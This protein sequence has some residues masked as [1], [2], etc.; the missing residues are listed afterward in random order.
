V[1]S[2][3]LGILIGVMVLPLASRAADPGPSPVPTAGPTGDPL[4]EVVVIGHYELFSDAASGYTN[5]PLPV[6]KIP[7][8]L[9]IVDADL[10]KAADL[11]TLADVADYTPGA[12]DVG[13]PGGFGAFISLRGFP[14]ANALDGINFSAISGANY[15]L[16]FAVMDRLE[17]IQGPSA[18]VYGV[19]SAGGLVNFVT[20][21]AATATPS[22]AILQGGSW[23]SW[24]FE[25][26][27]AGPLEAGGGAHGIAIA[28][29]DQGD[30][31]TDQ[32]QHQKVVLY[33]GANGNFADSVTAYVHGGYQKYQGTSFDGLPTE[34]DG[35]PAPLP[36]DFFIGSPQMT[37]N[38]LI[39]HAESNLTWHAGDALDVS[40][41][42]NAINSAGHGSTVP[43]SCCLDA[44]GNLVLDISD[45]REIKGWDYGAGI[46]ATYRLDQVGLQ[47]SFL[48][49][50]ALY[51]DDRFLVVAGSPSFAGEPTTTVNIFSGEAALTTAFDSARLIGEPDRSFQELKTLTLST[52]SVIEVLEHGSVLL[53]AAYSSPSLTNAFDDSRQDFHLPGNTLLRT[54]LMYEFAPHANAYASYS[55][56]F[57][58]QFLVDQQDR[59]LAPLVGSQYEIGVK[60]KPS[61][62]QLLLTAA[63]FAITQKNA[64]QFV[65]TVDGIDRYQ[66]IGELRHRGIELAA[67]GHVTAQWQINAGYTYLNARI[68]GDT[69]STIVGRTELFQPSRTASLFS[70]YTFANEFLRGFSA[71]AGVRYVGSERTAYDESTRDIPGYGLLDSSLAY[72]GSHWT[73]Q[74]NAHNLLN[75]YYFI[76]NYGSLLY[77]NAIGASSNFNVFVRREF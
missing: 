74:L 15:S 75:K 50:A 71:G 23:N 25:G 61:Q 20:K 53:G 5:L 58:P 36:R 44:A 30:D 48:S 72:I 1:A 9:G 39:Y 77:G 59:V 24:R 45:Y 8:S 65:D 41:S 10:L 73:V 70:T 35:S 68:A 51:Q 3:S 69:D 60:Y 37:I 54:A 27:L 13:N 4:E 16:D 17:I 49:V 2:W 38:F 21:S 7:Q 66:P 26:Q 62:E 46:S 43:Q 42:A 63:A 12:L 56:S 57:N 11:K 52:Q 6:E 31:F 76:N 55:E 19:S 40:F 32:V 47:K 64:G 28:V 33:L 67:L 29:V 18:V 34:A 14:S 22:Y